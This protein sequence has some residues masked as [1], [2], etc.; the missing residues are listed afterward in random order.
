[1]DKDA[2]EKFPKKLKAIRC[3]IR[4]T[5]YMGHEENSDM[6]PIVQVLYQSE[7]DFMDA[8]NSF[9]IIKRL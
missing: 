5:G 7:K 6:L 3:H 4:L 1:M 8:L 9:R 2:G